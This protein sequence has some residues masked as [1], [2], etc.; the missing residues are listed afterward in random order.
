MRPTLREV[1]YDYA[2]GP[3]TQN[4]LLKRLVQKQKSQKKEW[5]QSPHSFFWDFYFY[6]TLQTGSK[7]IKTSTAK[8]P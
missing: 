1:N 2:Q 8:N 4:Q 7:N 5:G 3:R 6:L